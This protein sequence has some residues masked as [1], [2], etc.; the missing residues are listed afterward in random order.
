MALAPSA[1]P[2]SALEPGINTGATRVV[3]TLGHDLPLSDTALGRLREID[4]HLALASHE[5]GAVAGAGVS[6]PIAAWAEHAGS[7]TNRQGLLQRFHAAV[8]PPGQAVVGWEAIVRLA[9]ATGTNLSW[10]QA[11][12]V[13]K[14]MTGAVAAWKGAPWGREV[15]P[16]QL[17]FAGS[18]G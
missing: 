6:L 13:W 9:R 17:R 4:L 16:T 12:D 1:Q 5:R 15:R 11:R 7:F 10:A 14:D 8:A 2:L 3:V 18:R